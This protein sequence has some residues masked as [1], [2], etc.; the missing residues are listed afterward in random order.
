[1]KDN[2][3]LSFLQKFNDSNKKEK[4]YMKE[5]KDSLWIPDN[6]CLINKIIM[7]PSVSIYGNKELI[8]I[9]QKFQKRKYFQKNAIIYF[10]D[11]DLN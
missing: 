6:F 11:E 7:T 3:L 5:V 8:P 2:D 4:D 1:M 9:C 10:R